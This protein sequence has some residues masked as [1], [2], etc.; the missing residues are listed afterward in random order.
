MPPIRRGSEGYEIAPINR[1]EMLARYIE[2]Q[3][4]EVGRYNLYVPEPDVDSESDGLAGVGGSDVD[5]EDDV[6]LVRKVEN[7]R[8]E[9]DGAATA[10]AE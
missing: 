3:A 2:G 1:E 10:A 5:D 7:W 6:P 8:A 4:A 9:T